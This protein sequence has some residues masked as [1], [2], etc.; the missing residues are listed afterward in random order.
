MMLLLCNCP[1]SRCTEKQ[2]FAYSNLD[3]TAPATL[4]NREN[5][6]LSGLLY[7]KCETIFNVKIYI[8]GG[9]GF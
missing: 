5:K 7:S 2:L 3:T 9:G 6:P 1:L 4:V 8:F